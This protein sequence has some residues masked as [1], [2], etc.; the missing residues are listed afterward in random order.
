MNAT[1]RPTSMGIIFILCL[2]FHI[3]LLTLFFT[4][5]LPLSL[6]KNIPLE[7]AAQDE[8]REEWVAMNGS[9][10]GAPIIFADYEE[11]E[12]SSPFAE[13]NT[14]LRETEPLV[15]ENNE[16]QNDNPSPQGIQLAHAKQT[17]VV[18]NPIEKKHVAEASLQEQVQSDTHTLE[19]KN[20]KTS[21]GLTFSKIANGFMQYM[22][23]PAHIPSSIRV[24]SQKKGSVSDKQIARMNFDQK[25]LNC[26]VNSYRIHRL[27]APHRTQKDR[28]AVAL[29]INR[30]GSIY[31]L[32]LLQSSG[33]VEI[34][35]FILAFFQDT[36]GSLPPIP[37][38]FSA[39]YHLP[40]ITFNDVRLF[41]SPEYWY[42]ATN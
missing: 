22:K 39:P 37:Q 14:G 7:M 26:I 6:E 29:A 11:D 12:Y 31:S 35:R 10:L 32:A 21:P 23:N 19:K 42:Y 41:Q 33:V 4:T 8:E 36:Q 38:Q 1:V 17:E 18:P 3:W 25:L 16:A 9:N 2:C 28:A 40:V 34:D 27:D 24:D 30:D 13:P 5:F 15:T 20:P